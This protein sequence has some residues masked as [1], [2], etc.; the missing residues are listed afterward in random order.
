[1]AQYEIRICK[2][3]GADSLV[4]ACQFFT[5]AAAIQAAQRIAHGVD[6]GVEIWRGM[7]C[8]YRSTAE[9]GQGLEL[10]GPTVN[11]DASPSV[12]PDSPGTSSS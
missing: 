9:P 4:Y 6:D 10:C 1:M 8:V 5:D 11:I 3:S 12:L 7:D 2:Q